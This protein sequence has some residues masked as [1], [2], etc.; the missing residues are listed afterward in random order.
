MLPFSDKLSPS[1]WLISGYLL[2][3]SLQSNELSNKLHNCYFLILALLC[4]TSNFDRFP[5]APYIYSPRCTIYKMVYHL[6]RN[7]LYF[8]LKAQTFLDTFRFQR[9]LYHWLQFT[10]QFWYLTQILFILTDIFAALFC[11]FSQTTF[12]AYLINRLHLLRLVSSGKC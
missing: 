6:S 2:W 1:I 9:Q 5:S 10:Q 8:H 12:V 3:L 4:S 7:V 11:V